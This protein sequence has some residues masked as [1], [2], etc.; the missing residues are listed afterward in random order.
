MINLLPPDYPRPRSFNEKLMVLIILF[1]FLTVLLSI[2]TFYI[3]KRLQNKAIENKIDI[4]EEKIFEISAETKDL[5]KIEIQKEKLAKSL[6]RRDKVVG[7]NIYWSIILNKLRGIVPDNSWLV[8]L[9]IKEH[10]ELTIEGY[11]INGDDLKLM[12]HNLRDSEV[13]LNIK[14][15]IINQEEIRYSKDY[16]PAEG[17]YYKIT[18]EINQ[19]LELADLEKRGDDTEI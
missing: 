5:K 7:K 1:S 15:N 18:G 13:F 14:L 6:A 17:F 2:T 9:S 16:Q 19:K 3:D 10:K 11:T 8:R 4:V 12:V